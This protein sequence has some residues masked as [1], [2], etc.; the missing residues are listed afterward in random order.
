[1]RY[2][3]SLHTHVKHAAPTRMRH[4]EWDWPPK[5]RRR[6]R[7]VINVYPRSGWGSPG[8]RK[9]VNIYWRVTITIIKML[10]AIPL[11]IMTVGAFWLFFVLVTLL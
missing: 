6:Y 3:G 11:A 4:E 8:V 1:M 5:R 9:A 2:H 7:G 10:I